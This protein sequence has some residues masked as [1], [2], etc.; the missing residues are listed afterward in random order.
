MRI[1]NKTTRSYIMNKYSRLVEIV[2]EDLNLQRSRKNKA[3]QRFREMAESSGY[4]DAIAW[5]SNDVLKSE[6][7]FR[8]LAVFHEVLIGIG[9][10][11]EML[12]AQVSSILDKHLDRLMTQSLETSTEKSHNLVAMAEFEAG[13]EYFDI[14]KRYQRFLLR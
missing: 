12:K 14:L 4:A 11:L 5:V 10:N 7:L 1:N 8:R 3:D 6:Y 9:D 13:R 2:A